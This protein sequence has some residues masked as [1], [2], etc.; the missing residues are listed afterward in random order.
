MA[1]RQSPTRPRWMRLDN[2][3]KI[4]PAARRNGWSSLFRLSMTLTE[5]VDTAVLQRALDVTVLRFPSISTRLKKGLFWYYLE[6]VNQPPEVRTESCYPMVYM[7]KKEAASCLFRV[8]VYGRRIAVEFFHSLTDGSGG[9]VFLK[10]LVAEYLQQRYGADIPNTHGILDRNEEPRAEELEDSFQ[11]YAGPVAAG[12]KQTAAWYVPGTPEPAGFANVTCLSMPVD[13]IRRKAKEYGL[14]VTNF[15][16]TVV[17]MAL[18]NHQRECQKNPMKRKPIKVQLPVNLR[19]IFPSRTLRNFALYVIPEIDPR[20]GEYSFEEIGKIVQS[21]MALGATDKQMGRTIAANVGSE[22]MLAVKLMPLFVKNIIMKAVFNAVGEKAYC[23]SLSNLGAIQLPEEMG[24]FV[25]RV[26]FIN[27]LQATRP[28]N[29]GVISW[30]D[31]LY[32]NFI[33]NI[34][35]P[36]VERHVACV[37]RDMGIS[38]EVQSNGR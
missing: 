21:Y 36:D 4:Y 24:R 26:D 9:L 38:I 20:L 5:P 30:G 22:R 2:A 27:G 10:T 31:T 1:S 23:L 3:A 19:N 34:Q 29:C 17:M 28:H 7:G 33:R 32:M 35:E 16:G 15:L 14:S 18:Q 6:Q 37:L 13:Q 25:E 11:K 8:V 12:R